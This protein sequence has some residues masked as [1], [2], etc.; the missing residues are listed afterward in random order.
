MTDD[1]PKKNKIRALRRAIKE[2]LKRRAK[3]IFMLWGLDEKYAVKSADHL[4][5]CSCWM[6]GNPRKYFKEKTMQEKKEDERYS[7]WLREICQRDQ[8]D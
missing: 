6:C 8:A 3:K 7:N 5:N 2:K 1:F 4:K